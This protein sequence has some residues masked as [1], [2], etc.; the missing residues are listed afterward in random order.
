MDLK[1]II[2]RIAKVKNVMK[3]QYSH[4]LINP[5]RAYF[6]K[7]LS[8]HVRMTKLM[9][10]SANLPQLESQHCGTYILREVLSSF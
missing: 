5:D 1:K 2:I 3:S 10:Y 4:L 6:P 8:F 9:N 7:L